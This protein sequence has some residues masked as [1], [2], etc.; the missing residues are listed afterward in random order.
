[1][2]HTLSREVT[3]YYSTAEASAELAT[4]IIGCL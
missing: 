2:L 4:Y 3:H 1:M